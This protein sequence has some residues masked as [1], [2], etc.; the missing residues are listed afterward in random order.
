MKIGII[1][2]GFVGTA[3]ANALTCE[4][5]VSDPELNGVRAVDLDYKALGA[6]FICVPTP[7][8]KYG[9][10]DASIIWKVLEDIPKDILTII[11]STVT[12]DHLLKMAKDR[13]IVFNPEFL[14]QRSATEDFIHCDSLIFGGEVDVYEP[15]APTV[16]HPWRVVAR[17]TGDIVG[18]LKTRAYSLGCS[19]A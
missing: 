14:T 8:G 18:R 5:I 15:I 6:V 19:W 17:L 1:G 10:V 3:L 4:V 16:H 7:V 9:A 11:K 2:K 12:P 13:R